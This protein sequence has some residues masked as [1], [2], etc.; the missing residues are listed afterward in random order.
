MSKSSSSFT[1][2]DLV[3]LHDS[4]EISWPEKIKR[5]L[6]ALKM[7]AEGV[8]Q[9]TTAKVLN[10]S[11]RTV[12]NYRDE[13]VD[14]GLES[15]VEDRAFRPVSSVEPYLSCLRCFFKARPLAS[16]KEGAHYIAKLTGVRLSDDQARRVMKK[17]GL[18]FCKSGQIPGKADPQLQLD[19]LQKELLPKLKEASEGKRKVFFVD[20]AH[21]VMGA[22]L[23]MLWCLTRVFTRTPSG[24]K[25]YNVLGAI[26]SHTRELFTVTNDS[27]INSTSVGALMW[28]IWDANRDVPITLVLDNARYQKCQVVHAMANYLGIE[29]LYLP[30]YSPNL[31]IIE[32]LWKYTK[33][34]C[35]YNK[36]YPKFD[37]FKAAIDGCLHRVNNDDSCKEDLKSLLTLNFQMFT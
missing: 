4:L 18:K 21:F 3:D 23:G 5:K 10:I 2:Q 36:Y 29:L 33:K 34:N 31:N 8:P 9:E 32:R 13:F 12:R 20:A 28:K 22:F 24:R 15:S 16:A 1:S 26:D 14:G 19:F 17:I 6:L 25:R 30:P 27:Y 37:Q 35:L 7:L 11:T